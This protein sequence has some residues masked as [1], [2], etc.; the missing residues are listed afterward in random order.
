MTSGGSLG[1]VG[2]FSFAIVRYSSN[3]LVDDF[4]NE[5]YPKTS[6]EYLSGRLIEVGIVWNA[7]TTEAEI[8]WLEQHI[9]YSYVYD[10]NRIFID[11]IEIA[12]IESLELPYYSIQK[13]LDNDMSY[14]PDA[15]EESFDMPSPIVYGDFSTFI[16]THNL[17][18]PITFP[19]VCVD[20]KRLRYICASHEFYTELFSDSGSSLMYRY[21]DG[22]D[23]YMSL[24]CANGSATNV[25]HIGYITNFDT[26]NSV[27]NIIKGR[28]LIQPNVPGKLNNLDGFNAVC[29]DSTD[30][31]IEIPEGSIISLRFDGSIG[32]VGQLSRAADRVVL[33]CTATAATGLGN[34]DAFYHNI[35]YNSGVGGN[36]VGELFVFT[37]AGNYE[38]DL[39]AD[40]G[41]RD[42]IDK[43]WETNELDILEYHVLASDGTVTLQNLYLKIDNIIVSDPRAIKKNDRALIRNTGFGRSEYR[44]TW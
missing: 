42:V 16:D 29:D 5:F 18:K 35:E 43:P 30:T 20:K 41:A 2:N 27:D 22:V 8:T 31:N 3:T 11:C 39:S 34:F 21:L 26:F 23:T 7:A 44:G 36:S 17:F 6:G 28:I 25:P 4:F 15:P 1:Q 33:I 19:L 32:N 24:R 40:F 37:T 9:I 13:D 38:Y 12:E 14:F 10:P